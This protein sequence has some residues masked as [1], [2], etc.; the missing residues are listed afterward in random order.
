M[1]YDNTQGCAKKSK[2]NKIQTVYPQCYRLTVVS[3]KRIKFVGLDDAL[4]IVVR[5]K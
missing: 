1:V 3:V 4:V 2:C 5:R